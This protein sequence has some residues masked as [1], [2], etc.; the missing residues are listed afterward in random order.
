MTGIIKVDTIQNNGG[1]T[2]I[3]LNSAGNAKMAGHVVQHVE[4]KRTSSVTLTSGVY[5]D[6]STHSE[7]TECRI[8]FTPKF[9]DSK[10]LITACAD[11][12]FT[13]GSLGTWVGIRRDDVALFTGADN[14]SNLTN[15]EGS[16]G[17]DTFLF[18]YRSDG[19]SANHH[20]TMQRSLLYDAASTNAQVFKFMFARFSNTGTSALGAWGPTTLSI[21]EIAQ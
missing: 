3:T 7:V 13:G 21:T 6:G 12:K 8:T 11:L 1:T 17:K 5:S 14:G 15:T 16:T 19:G 2:N 4:A 10:L 9:S 18:V 20:H